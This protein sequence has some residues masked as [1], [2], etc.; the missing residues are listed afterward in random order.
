M[1]ERQEKY[2]EAIRE[3]EALLKSDG[4]GDEEIKNARTRIA[5]LKP[6]TH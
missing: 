4:I 6:Q 1:L 3:Y 2:A 5:A